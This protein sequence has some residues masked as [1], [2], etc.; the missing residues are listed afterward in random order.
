[1]KTITTIALL[2]PLTAFAWDVR[3]VQNEPIMTSKDMVGQTMLSI[4]TENKD[5]AHPVLGVANYL[6]EKYEESVK[7]QGKFKFPSAL[8]F[9][10]GQVAALP[11]Q[12]PQILRNKPTGNGV[13][14]YRH[15]PTD[16]L[17][18]ALMNTETLEFKDPIFKD[19]DWSKHDNRDFV[20]KFNEFMGLCFE[21]FGLKDLPHNHED[22]KS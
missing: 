16:K 2:L 18:T 13:L 10:D 17:Y 12:S 15:V 4:S 20:L 9:S 22:E 8:R 14:V 6:H 21:M 7:A 1:M 5:C 11:P 3:I 19:D